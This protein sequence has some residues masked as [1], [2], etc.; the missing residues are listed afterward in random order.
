MTSN[1]KLFKHDDPSAN[2]NSFD[3][4]KALNENWDKLDENA[5]AVNKKIENIEQSIEEEKKKMQEYNDNAE[6]LKEKV[7]L[8][9]G[10]LEDVK[11]SGEN[12]EIDDALEYYT[13][14]HKIYGKS[15][16]ETR[17][18][19]QESVTGEKVTLT[20]VDPNKDIDISIDGNNRQETTTGKQLFNKDGDLSY[21]NNTA[22]TNAT[23]L[24]SDGTLK[25]NSN[26][27][28]N[29]SRGARLAVLKANTIYTVKGKIKSMTHNV[30]IRIMGYST[31]WRAIV[32]PIFTSIG[33]FKFTFN[34]SSEYSDFFLSLNGYYND[35][36]T[37]T[38]AIFD[39]VMVYEGTDDISYEKY[40][41][42]MESPSDKYPS[43]I[44]IIDGCNI[45]DGEIEL[46]W[47]DRENGE[48]LVD[49]TK[50]RSKNFIPVKPNTE[51]T[52]TRESGVYRWI[53]GYTKEK[54]G[55]TDGNWSGAKAGLK[56]TADGSIKTIT[57]TTSPT[58]YY[59]KWYDSS[60]TNL[61]EKVAI[62]EG[63]EEKPYLPHGSI[64]LKFSGKNFLKLQDGTYTN[65]G[66]TCVVSDGVITANGTASINTVCN[67]PIN[68]ITL[69]GTYILSSFNT[70]E[71][72]N[73][74]ARLDGD[75]ETYYNL[76]NA[77]AT[78]T[79]TKN[80]NIKYTKYVFRTTGGT[81]LN[82]FIVK[83]MLSV[84]V[85]DYEPYHEPQLIQ[86]DLAGN[87][88]DKISDTI[89][90]ELEIYRNGKITLKKKVNR[91]SFSGNE[92]I[93]K[94]TNYSTDSML[95]VQFNK[96]DM[97]VGTTNI[98]CNY[99][100]YSSSTIINSI[101]AA[102]DYILFGLDKATFTDVDSF[103]SYLL[104]QYENETAVYV[105]YELATPQQ[106]ELP[107]IDPLQL[108]E[109]TVNV[110]LVS[111][112][113]TNLSVNYNIVP[114]MPSLEARSDIESTVDN[115]KIDIK[116]QN[117]NILNMVDYTFKGDNSKFNLVLKNGK[118]IIY[119]SLSK[120]GTNSTTFRITDSFKE[121]NYAQ[122]IN[123]NDIQTF[124]TRGKYYLTIRCLSGSISTNAIINFW[125]RF[126]NAVSGTATRVGILKGNVKAEEKIKYSFELQETKPFALFLYVQR[127]EDTSYDNFT[128]EVM[129]EKD[130]ETENFEEH[131]EVN[132]QMILNKPLKGIKTNDSTKANYI[133]ENGNYWITDYVA[134]DGIHRKIGEISFDGTENSWSD[135]WSQSDTDTRK[136]FSLQIKSIK[137][138]TKNRQAICNFF[139]YTNSNI[140]SKTV[141]ITAFH[142]NNGANFSDFIYF[143]IEK[144][145]LPTPDLAGWKALLAQLKE[146]NTPLTVQYELGKETLEEFT[147]EEKKSWN[148]FKKLKTFKGKN[149]ISSV[150]NIQA[151]I[152]F[153]Y[154]KDNRISTQKE[155]E[156]CNERLNNIENLLNTTETSSL[157]LDNLENDLKKEVE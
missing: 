86:I 10:N 96:S 67:I 32:E 136:F 31:N 143:K 6:I 140:Q 152:E 94:N 118:A 63:T 46:G 149:Y 14:N 76:E 74:Q 155:L 69:N 150:D 30:R 8:L 58:T 137:N 101:R 53:V 48:L 135:Q 126:D 60:C 108:W 54:V 141:D 11:A 37:I 92:K 3:I 90:D 77:N 99:F 91:Y 43:K 131:R 33:D 20:N 80:E 109:G 104:Q 116:Q 134:D 35:S 44:E 121:G 25:S 70:I 81:T 22:Y 82:N 71:N 65:N 123:N 40:T 39:E 88:I 62:T 26:A 125:T 55:I 156:K 17:E 103:K 120:K 122:Y 148:E 50:T 97:K 113:A 85:G 128:F 57:F 51:Y 23:V 139:K 19:S 64:G 147:E 36:T 83:P 18:F 42:G 15:T 111:N 93:E 127:T 146:N 52:F 132:H 142:F 59:I 95:V 151:G 38:E 16:Q 100:K 87:S 145:L 45:F 130:E 66:I 117:K 89:K 61:S 114:A 79:F 112:L 24:L 98:L 13:D 84:D 47:I 1:L 73:V 78:H 9:E 129:L 102:G 12:I 41:G 115:G 68:E 2:T 5:G 4:E 138:D 28:S 119:G 107:S 7:E 110:E 133:D 106:I 34:T 72:A 105:D 153:S 157:L 27:N 21:P 154:K 29:A 56:S 49:D 75:S 124:L 144:F